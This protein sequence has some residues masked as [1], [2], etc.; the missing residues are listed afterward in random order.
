MRINLM[1]SRPLVLIPG[2]IHPDGPRNR[3]KTGI[4]P[5]FRPYLSSGCMNHLD[6]GRIG[7]V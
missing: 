6:L 1:I 4:S 3:K 5:Y 2:G 7:E